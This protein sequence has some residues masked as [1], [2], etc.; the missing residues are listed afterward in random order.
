MS[1]ELTDDYDI[2]GAGF[3]STHSLSGAP[4]VDESGHIID[5][6]QGQLFTKYENSVFDNSAPL[7]NN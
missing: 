4:I 7:I 2:Y 6:N 5:S 3:E 1:K